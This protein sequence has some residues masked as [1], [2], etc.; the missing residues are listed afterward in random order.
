MKRGLLYAVVAIS[1]VGFGWGLAKAQTAGPDFELVVDAPGGPTNIQC[2]RGCALMWV[3]RGV[4]PNGTPTKTFSFSCTAN[5]CQSG[6]VGGW[7]GP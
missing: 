1:L 3:Q 2:V 6:A 7:I 4:N 5:R